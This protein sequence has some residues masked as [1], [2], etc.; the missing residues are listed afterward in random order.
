MISGRAWIDEDEAV[1]AFII[2]SNAT[3]DTKIVGIT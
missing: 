1:L 2:M 3:I